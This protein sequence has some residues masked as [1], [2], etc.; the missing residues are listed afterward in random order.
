MDRMRYDAA[1]LA[2]KNI[3]SGQDAN[4]ITSAALSIPDLLIARWKLWK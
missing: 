1:G 3:I 4:Y 2:R